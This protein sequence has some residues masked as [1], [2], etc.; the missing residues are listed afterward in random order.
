MELERTRI[1]M[2]QGGEGISDTERHKRHAFH[3]ITALEFFSLK[4]RINGRTRA[5]VSVFRFPPSHRPSMGP[6]N[7]TSE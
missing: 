7:Y 4:G 1:L 6:S 2:D 5:T 3:I